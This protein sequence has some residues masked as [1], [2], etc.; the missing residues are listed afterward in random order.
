[1]LFLCSHLIAFG[2]KSAVIP[3]ALSS[4]YPDFFQDFLSWVLNNLMKIY[5]GVVLFILLDLEFFEFIDL[6]V[7]NFSHDRVRP[8]IEKKH[9]AQK[10]GE[11]YF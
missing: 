7:H 2:Q 9:Q 3:I 1:M 8:R 5:L 6:K 11:S 10:L 4:L